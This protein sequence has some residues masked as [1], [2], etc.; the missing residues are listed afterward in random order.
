MRIG[1]QQNLT[2]ELIHSA[3]FGAGRFYVGGSPHLDSLGYVHQTVA[4][5]VA[6]PAISAQ[7]YCCCPSDVTSQPTQ[8]Q[9]GGETHYPQLGLDS[10]GAGSEL[11]VPLDPSASAEPMATTQSNVIGASGLVSSGLLI[12][13]MA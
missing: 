9:G 10:A 12:D 11:P 5:R 3:A 13:V 2:I 1:S 8:R 6:S 4:M 7:Q